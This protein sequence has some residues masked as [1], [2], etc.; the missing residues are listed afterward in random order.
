MIH[1]SSKETQLFWTH[2]SRWPWVTDPDPRSCTFCLMVRALAKWNILQ[3]WSIY[4]LPKKKRNFP[5]CVS[6]EGE[7]IR[8]CFWAG[9]LINRHP[10]WSMQY[11]LMFLQGVLQNN[12][13]FV[14]LSHVSFRGLHVLFRQN[15]PNFLWVTLWCWGVYHKAISQLS[16]PFQGEMGLFSCV[17]FLNP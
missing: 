16:G 7:C 8:I 9:I 1:S 2:F 14:S 6:F 13:F 3:S 11:I 10:E 15:G 17:H 5:C 12:V 4:T